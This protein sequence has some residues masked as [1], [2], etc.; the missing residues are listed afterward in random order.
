MWIT[1]Y[2]EQYGLELEQLGT[3]IRRAGRR[4][5]PELWV[6]DTLL[7]RLET[8]PNFRTV[9]KLADLIAEPFGARRPAPRPAGR[10]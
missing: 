8:D 2:R 4:K 10:A 9:P 3:M 5:D 1:E 6:S 7:Y